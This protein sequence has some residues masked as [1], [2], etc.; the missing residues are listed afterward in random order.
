MSE[1]RKLGRVSTRE[2]GGWLGQANVAP[3]GAQEGKGFEESHY[4]CFV[5]IDLH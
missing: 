2:R 4:F 1:G 3:P 5:C